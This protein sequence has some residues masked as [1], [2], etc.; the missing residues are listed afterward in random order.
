V[1]TLWVAALRLW[2]TDWTDQLERVQVLTL[3]GIILGLLLGKS[4]FSATVVR[5]LVF[6]YSL[7][8]LPW[9]IA[10][11]DESPVY[12]L[13]LMIINGRLS[14]T[15][16]TFMRNQPVQDSILFIVTMAILFWFIAVM[17]SYMLVRYNRP[18]VPVG[19]AAVAV[20]LIEY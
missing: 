3:L 4:M 20:I 13:R 10:F 7:V 14:T 17:S 1:A 11:L 6:L 9:Q 12:V 18:W 2:L 8:I 15:L 5:W 16:A 19:V